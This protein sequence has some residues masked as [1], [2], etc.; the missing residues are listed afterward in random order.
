[1]TP[2]RRRPRFAP[3]RSATPP[4]GTQNADHPNL[5]VVSFSM[6]P[7]VPFRMSF[8][9]DRDR[10]G[11]RPPRRQR[12]ALCSGYH[13]RAQPAKRPWR[14][15]VGV[16]GALAR[17]PVRL[18]PRPRPGSPPHSSGRGRRWSA[19]KAAA[20]NV[21]IARDPRVGEPGGMRS[22]G[23]WAAAA[24]AGRPVLLRASLRAGD[25]AIFSA[26]SKGRHGLLRPPGALR[27]GVA[28]RKDGVG[29]YER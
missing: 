18:P 6:S 21:V 23:R 15:L 19:T 10:R 3:L 8:D 26:G 13:A 11:R 1:M 27:P 9:S 24:A 22:R 17:R 7:P 2:L 28:P 4:C 12:P 16:G 29:S 20:N 14:A 5:P 25:G